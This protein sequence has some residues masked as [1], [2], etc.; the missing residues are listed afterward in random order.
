M[1]PRLLEELEAGFGAL[2]PR[3]E[4]RQRFLVLQSPQGQLSPTETNLGRKRTSTSAAIRSSSSTASRQR[5]ISSSLPLRSAS[6]S[7]VRSFIFHPVDSLTT[8]VG[9]VFAPFS[10]PPILGLFLRESRPLDELPLRFPVGWRFGF[11]CCED[12]PWEV[13]RW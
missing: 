9:L 1:L 12:E 5:A 6:I 4:R 8:A 3:R 2:G 7:A 11:E 10:G 13:E